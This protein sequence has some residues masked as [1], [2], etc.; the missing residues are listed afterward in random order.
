MHTTLIYWYVGW[1]SVVAYA[2]VVERFNIGR[3]QLSSYKPYENALYHLDTDGAID[4]IDRPTMGTLWTKRN[5]S[6]IYCIFFI[7]KEHTCYLILTTE[8]SAA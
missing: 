7:L 4:I 6:I 8:L 3:P 5:V 1:L 2:V